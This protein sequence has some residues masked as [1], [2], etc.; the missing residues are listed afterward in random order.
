ML[1]HIY[2]KQNFRLYG[3]KNLNANL[4]PP[5]TAYLEEAE[6]QFETAVESEDIDFYDLQLIKQRFLKLKEETKNDIN[7]N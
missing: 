5:I 7:P 3:M 1:R 2:A 4:Q 6:K